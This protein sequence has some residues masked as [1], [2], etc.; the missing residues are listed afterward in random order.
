MLTF[1]TLI[2][3]R[4]KIMA[5]FVRVKSIK[6]EFFKINKKFKNSPPVYRCLLPIAEGTDILVIKSI[7]IERI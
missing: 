6:V 1:I 3:L 4:S 7:N 5:V 2:F